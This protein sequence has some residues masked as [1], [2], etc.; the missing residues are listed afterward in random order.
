MKQF[1]TIFLFLLLL[2]N[3]P[4]TAQ[5]ATDTLPGQ[6]KF[7]RHMA[8]QLCTRIQEA[9]QKQSFDQLSPK[10]ADDLFMSLMMSSMGDQATEFSALLSAARSRKVNTNKLG[11]DMGIAAVKQLSVDC[12]SSMAL[13]IRTSSAQREL[14]NKNSKSANNISA[15][16]KV[17]L[18]PMADSVCAKIAAEDARLPLKKRTAAQRSELMA[19]V[20]QTTV[21]K[22]M[23]GLLTVYSMEQIQNKTSMEAFGIKLAT[24]MMTRCPLYLIMMGEDNQKSQR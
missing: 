7:T 11:H 19:T 6:A 15:D 9:S 24:L 22:N 23:S 17:V 3:L 10:Q 18:Q 20:M 14:G 1:S 21:L 12:P 2:V 5:T 4:A 8:A 13:L 16:E